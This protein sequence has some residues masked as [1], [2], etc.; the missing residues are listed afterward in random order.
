MNTNI[1]EMAY[2]CP[3]AKLVGSAVLEDHELVFKSHADIEVKPGSVT[4]GAVWLITPECE[5]NLDMLEGF[6]VYYEKKT[7]KVKINK[8]QTVDAMVYYMTGQDRTGQQPSWSYV[9]CVLEGYIDNRISTKQI[10]RALS[11]TTVEV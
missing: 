6:P 8:G 9:D 3:R 2:R 7:V 4:E 11:K 5:I 1:G 10:F